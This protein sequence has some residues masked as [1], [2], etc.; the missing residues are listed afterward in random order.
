MTS[1]RTSEPRSAVSATGC[2]GGVTEVS[3]SSTSV[4][5][6]AQTAERGIIIIMKV[7]IITDITICIR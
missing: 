5:R 7:A 6:S 1:S 2:A 3:V 4:I